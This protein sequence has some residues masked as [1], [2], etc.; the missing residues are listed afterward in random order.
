MDEKIDH[1]VA[2]KEGLEQGKNI[3][4]KE[5]KLYNV[6]INVDTIRRRYPI[7]WTYQ[8]GVESLIVD[9]KIWVF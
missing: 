7:K 9:T 4:I 8:E 2:L 3:G 5:N 6:P 1:N